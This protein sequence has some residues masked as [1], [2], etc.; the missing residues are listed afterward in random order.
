MVR[1]LEPLFYILSSSNR[2]IFRWP[3]SGHAT[4]Y[5][6]QRCTDHF[7]LSCVVWKATHLDIDMVI[8]TEEQWDRIPLFSAFI[9]D[10]V[11]GGLEDVI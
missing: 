6:L 9:Y 3:V 10:S 7:A 2:G 5:G 1:I 4:W 8:C 11:D